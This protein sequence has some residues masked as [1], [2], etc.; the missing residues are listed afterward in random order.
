VILEFPG[1]SNLTA[2]D[3]FPGSISPVSIVFPSSSEQEEHH[4]GSPGATSHGDH[5]D[6]LRGVVVPRFEAMTAF[7][8][9]KRDNESPSIARSADWAIEA[10]TRWQASGNATGVPEVNCGLPWRLTVHKTAGD[11][12]AIS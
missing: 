8:L 12:T 7:T 11:F 3:D 5:Q 2:F 10:R 6:V 4:S 1:F 9:T